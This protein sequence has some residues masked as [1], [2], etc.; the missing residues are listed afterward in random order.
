MVAKFLQTLSWY[1]ILLQKESIT[2]FMIV[3][4]QV[5]ADEFAS[6]ELG[7]L[8]FR[9]LLKLFQTTL[10]FNGRSTPNSSESLHY[11][12]KKFS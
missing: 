1:L 10:V 5:K 9:M 12:P 6:E 7:S 8:T 2:S 11:L 3:L 4:N